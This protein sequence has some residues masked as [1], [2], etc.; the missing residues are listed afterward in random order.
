MFKNAIIIISYNVCVDNLLYYVYFYDVL[1]ITSLLPEISVSKT[2]PCKSLYAN[3]THALSKNQKHQH[4]NDCDIHSRPTTCYHAVWNQFRIL[5][6]K[7][8]TLQY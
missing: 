2:L 1:I 3:L 7:C 4:G 6:A 8:H 5:R